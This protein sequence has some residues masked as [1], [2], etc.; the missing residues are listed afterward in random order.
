MHSLK[1]TDMQIAVNSQEKRLADSLRRVNIK[2]SQFTW[3]E[4][5]SISYRVQTD[6][7]SVSV[8]IEHIHYFQNTHKI[9]VYPCSKAFT[10]GVSCAG[11]KR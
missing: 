8:Q 4:S 11:F 7:L 5:M 1:S 10:A 9:N 6:T 2:K 3:L